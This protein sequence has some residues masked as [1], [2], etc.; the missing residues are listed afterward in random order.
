MCLFRSVSVRKISFYQINILA[1]V[2]YF[3]TMGGSRAALGDTIL[4][5]GL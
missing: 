5:N 4:K 2:E 3:T 1:V